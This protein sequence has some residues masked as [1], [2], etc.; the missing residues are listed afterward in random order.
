MEEA[1]KIFGDVLVLTIEELGKW[2]GVPNPRW[3]DER[4][5]CRHATAGERPAL[6]NRHNS[7][8]PAACP[9]LAK[10]EDMPDGFCQ[11]NGYS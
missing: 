1:I 4:Q 5:W 3:A 11:L 2:L 7:T 8:G 6:W 9:M 10:D